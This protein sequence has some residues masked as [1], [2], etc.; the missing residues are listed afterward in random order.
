MDD[1]S[2]RGLFVSAFVSATLFPGGSEVV[3]AALGHGRH[4]RPGTLLR[5]ATLG[6]TLGGMST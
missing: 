1:L 6:N 2:L 4:Y 3:L 5:V